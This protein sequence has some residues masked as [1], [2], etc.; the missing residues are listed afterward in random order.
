MYRYLYLSLHSLKTLLEHVF[1]RNERHIR[2]LIY[3]ICWKIY[4]WIFISLIY[5]HTLSFGYLKHLRISFCF[6]TYCMILCCRFIFKTLVTNDLWCVWYMEMSIKKGF[7]NSKR[8]IA[9]SKMQVWIEIIGG[10]F[11]RL[12]SI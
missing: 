4:Y 3:T 1:S 6:L 11:G 8:P 5:E 10:N 12:I 7:W 9:V 2:L